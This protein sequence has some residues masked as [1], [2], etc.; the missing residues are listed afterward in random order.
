MVLLS[1]A[2]HKLVIVFVGPNPKPDNV[3]ILAPS[4]G[5][6]MEPNI[7]RPDIPFLGKTQGWM[8]RI[9][10]EEREFLISKIL[11]FFGEVLVAFPKG[12][13]S[14]RGY[15]HRSHLPERKSS[16]TWCSKRTP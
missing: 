8:E 2:I 6:V 5:A 15:F 1:E 13:V 12:S 7:N 11:D 9:R 10:P 14:I 3:F 4:N 16:F